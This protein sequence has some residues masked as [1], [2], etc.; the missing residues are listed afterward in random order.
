MSETS[1]L[2]LESVELQIFL[3]MFTWCM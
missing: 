1:S 2:R 3:I